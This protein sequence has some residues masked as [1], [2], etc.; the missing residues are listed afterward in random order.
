[1]FEHDPGDLGDD[2]LAELFER[3]HTDVE[4]LLLAGY[5]RPATRTP[6]PLDLY[7]GLDTLPAIDDY[8]PAR[9]SQP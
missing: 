7:R 5:G 9:N 8:R 6:Q 2:E 3:E 1:M 4:V